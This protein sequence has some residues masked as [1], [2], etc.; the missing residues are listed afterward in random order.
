M[1]V[2]L[3]DAGHRDDLVDVSGVERDPSVSE[4]PTVTTAPTDAGAI[5]STR[6]TWNQLC[7]VPATGNGV[8]PAWLPGSEM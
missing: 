7:V 6:V 5:T 3:V 2:A 4:A 8:R 1:T